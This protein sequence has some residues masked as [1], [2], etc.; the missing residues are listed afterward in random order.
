ME[1]CTTQEG[2]AWRFVIIIILGT[3]LHGR[4]VDQCHLFIGNVRLNLRTVSQPYPLY[5]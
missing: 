5:P 3:N 4:N 2:G 1:Y